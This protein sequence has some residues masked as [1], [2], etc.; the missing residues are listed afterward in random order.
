MS[1]RALARLEQDSGKGLLAGLA[2]RVVL[3]SRMGCW[4]LCTS[5]LHKTVP[6]SAVWTFISG[7]MLAHNRPK[8][9]TPKS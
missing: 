3:C 4:L 1:L 7:K 6:E 9:L 5:P 2:R 8:P